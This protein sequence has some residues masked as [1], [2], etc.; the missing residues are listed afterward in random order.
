MTW[1]QDALLVLIGLLV[2]FD[3]WHGL[4][5]R[6]SLVTLKLVALLALALFVASPNITKLRLSGNEL[7]LERQATAVSDV[8]ASVAALGISPTEGQVTRL[9][10]RAAGVETEAWVRLVTTRMALR[11]LLRA[12]CRKVSTHMEVQ[13]SSGNKAQDCPDR[14][15]K[16]GPHSSEHQLTCLQKHGKLDDLR[17]GELNRLRRTTE[18]AEWGGDAPPVEELEFALREG[19][20]ILKE[21]A[22]V[23]SEWPPPTP[24]AP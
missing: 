6:E 3:L 17:F 10:D 20:R 5:K 13:G 22:Q 8:M 14:Y 9:F 16:P 19:P 4:A 18:F 7:S 2:L 21:L 15:G 23:G 24:A 11:S 1:E 12:A